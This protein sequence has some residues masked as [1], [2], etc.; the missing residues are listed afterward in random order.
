MKKVLIALGFVL[1]SAQSSL[2]LIIKNEDE[3]TY[4]LTFYP[5]FSTPVPI[6]LGPRE[7]Y[8][9]TCNGRCAIKVGEGT[10]IPVGGKDLVLLRG[11]VV[12]V[13]PGGY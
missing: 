4:R 3:R 7:E 6:Q 10:A 13:K 9:A 1:L 2:A 5:F 11:G 8:N 12:T